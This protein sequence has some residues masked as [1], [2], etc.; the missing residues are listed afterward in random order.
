MNLNKYIQ[1][2]VKKFYSLINVDKINNTHLIIGGI[3]LY[4]VLFTMNKPVELINFIKKPLIMF[5]SLAYILYIFNENPTISIALAIAFIIT[6]STDTDITTSTPIP[7][8][9]G[10]REHFKSNEDDSDESENESID[11]N[12]SDDESENSEEENDE[13][14]YEEEY[15]EDDEEEE[16]EDEEEFNGSN[17]VSKNNINDTFKN[18]HDAIHKLENFISEE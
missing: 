8:I 18:L 6:V 4:I 2:I 3:I 10:K 11:S 15:E 7:I 13:H 12:E 5:S 9:H 16:L 17:I 1:P 14:D